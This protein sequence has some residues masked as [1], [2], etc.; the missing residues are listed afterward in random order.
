MT[1]H[2]LL[3][4]ADGIENTGP[5]WASWAF[6][7][8]RFCGSL[9][10]ATRNRRFPWAS[11]TNYLISISQVY[12][13]KNKRHAASNS[14]SA[15]RHAISRAH[16]VSETLEAEALAAQLQTLQPQV[17]RLAQQHVEH[18]IVIM[19]S[20]CAQKAYEGLVHNVRGIM[21][22]NLVLAKYLDYRR[23]PVVS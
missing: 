10:N 1:I 8:E 11:M 15:A 4:I 6:P 5:V 20:R 17:E 18:A 12:Q 21:Q 2:A 13:I 19:E 23:I 16:L 14:R 9:Q 3:H 22:P 7:M